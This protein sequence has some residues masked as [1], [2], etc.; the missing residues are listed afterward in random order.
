MVALVAWVVGLPR[1]LKHSSDTRPVLTVQMELRELRSEVLKVVEKPKE[2][3]SIYCQ[4]QQTHKAQ[5]AN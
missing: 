5:L 3:L 4:L 1:Q 2:V